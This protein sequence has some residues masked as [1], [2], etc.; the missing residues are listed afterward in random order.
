[1]MESEVNFL[2][3]NPVA[4]KRTKSEPPMGS[5]VF[6]ASKPFSESAS[7]AASRSRW[8]ARETVRKWSGSPSRDAS[9]MMQLR[10]GDLRTV[11]VLQ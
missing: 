11:R 3:K 5:S 6:I 9:D 2:N 7:R 8:S 10:H 4:R 1:M